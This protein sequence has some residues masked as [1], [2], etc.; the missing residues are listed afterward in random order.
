MMKSESM[1]LN[2]H[3]FARCARLVAW[4]LLA[5]LFSFGA[6]RFAVAADAAPPPSDTA[7]SAA[8]EDI[9]PDSNEPELPPAGPGEMAVPLDEAAPPVL[10]TPAPQGSGT[11][12]RVEV[13]GAQRIEPDSVLSYLLLH[14][15]QPYDPATADRSLKVL[16]DTGL[17]ADVR[18][19]WDG[20]TLTVV[21][22][23]NPILNQVVYEGNST[24][25]DA[26]LNMEVQV[27]PRMVFTRARV[28]A[29]VG[30][31]IELFRRSGHFAATVEPKII[32]RPQNRVDLVFEINEGPLTGVAAINFIGNRVFSDSDLR[33]QIVTTTS[34]WWKFLSTN[35]NY[36][37]DRLTF[38]REQLR[39][40][41]LGQG[42]A[43][44]RVVSAAA[45]LT[46]DRRDFYITFT[47]DEGELY[48]FDKINIESQIRDLDPEQLRPLLLTE[49]GDTY[50]ATLIDRSIEALTYAAGT[51]GFVF[52]DISPRVTRNADNRTIDLTF[53]INEAPR[54]YVERINI[55]GNSRTR[56]EVIRR[57]FR[58]AEGDAFN[59]VLTDRSRTRVRALGFFSDVVIREDPGASP[60]RTVLTVTVAEQPTGELALGAGFSSQQ[61][62]LVDF[63]YTERNLF[64]RGQFLRTSVSIGTYQKNYDFRFTEPY[65]MGRPLAAGFLLYKVITDFSQQI[66]YI[67]SVSALGL[68]MGFPV[69]EFGRLSPHYNY[70]YT[71]ISP[72]FGSSIAIQLAAGHYSTSSIGFTYSYDTRDDIIRP[73]KGWNFAFSQDISG[74]GGDLKFLR[75]V[76]AVEYWH[77]FFF[78]L[79][80]NISVSAGYIS[81]FGA[82]A[83]PI[84]ERFFKG[85]PSFRGFRIAGVGPRDTIS[86]AALGGQAFAIGT[87]QVRLPQILPQDYGITLSAFS[88]FG[89]LGLIRGQQK[90]CTFSLCIKDDMALRVTAGIA[91]NWRSPFG[92][93]EIDVGHPL[94]MESY[95][96]PEAIRFSAGTQF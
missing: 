63:S 92:P 82:Q 81:G 29:D 93:V 15:G 83:V 70:Q 12:T 95:D 44:F 35:D 61:G 47:V 68:Q 3:P 87:Y 45:E 52:V 85:G 71:D 10:L 55:V 46:P 38:D 27:R 9:T 1:T 72:I 50:D 28:Q 4:V 19:D 80:A 14:T 20:S 79:V 11:I 78:D 54:V 96:K 37:P 18:L 34:A 74:L 24:L 90:T 64:G 33:S 13:Q 31:I 36:D 41:Y 62:I 91:I 86:E 21:V 6:V 89:T 5:L 49:Q 17:F 66:G 88:D 77:P 69:S 75:S 40:F 60:D 94:V 43:D 48:T 65:F 16:F 56:D 32:Q 57:E 22:V 84:N 59:R 58:I 39:R 76:G 67:S 25:S 8:G 42:Y 53:T 73:T 26:D 30:R 7:P 51:R 2:G 23:E